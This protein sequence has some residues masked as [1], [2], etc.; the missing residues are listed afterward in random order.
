MVQYLWE[1]YATNNFAFSK[2]DPDYRRVYLLNIILALGM[3]VLVSFAVLN[4]I[5]FT[6]TYLVIL[7]IFS[8]ILLIAISVYFHKTLNLEK[9][10]LL[11][12]LLIILVLVIYFQLKEYR[13]YAL[14]WI[15]V[16]PPVVYFLLEKKKGRVVTAV[17]LGFML[18]FILSRYQGWVEESFTT[19]SIY[20]IV[21]ASLAMTV[22]IGYYELSREEAFAALKE[23]NEEL[24]EI[25]IKDTLTGLYNRLKLDQVL[26]YEVNRSNR[27]GEGFSV[28][29]ADLDRFKLIND[30]YGH[31][32]G[33]HLLIKISDI[34]RSSCRKIDIVGRWGGEEFLIICP[35][36][37][38]AG[39][40]NLAERIRSSIE[41]HPFEEVGQ[42]TISLGVATYSPGDTRET[43]VKAADYALYKAKEKGRNR[44]EY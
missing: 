3:V 35:G 21:I 33:D 7:N 38:T 6:M 44:V 26:E 18:F 15:T 24:T 17:F 32:K 14:Y 40:I 11:T 23:K 22:M 16:I 42:V 10:A 39:G 27:T 34:M 25:S 37:N 41:N 30:T 5:I 29:M 19:D 1:K 2:E 8:F 20:N 28:I 43:I 4:I 12:T 9:T 31:I 13:D 36:V